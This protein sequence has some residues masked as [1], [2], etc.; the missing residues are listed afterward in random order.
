MYSILYRNR[1]TRLV[2]KL[3][4]PIFV[5][6]MT[7][8]HNVSTLAKGRAMNADSWTTVSPIV[9]RPVQHI[10]LREARVRIIVVEHTRVQRTVT[11]IEMAMVACAKKD[12]MASCARSSVMM[13]V[14]MGRHVVMAMDNAI[15]QRGSLSILLAT[16]KKI[17]KGTYVSAMSTLH[18]AATGHAL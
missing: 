9:Q 12:G 1:S 5:E 4:K 10:I 8:R 2:R 18:A 15:H 13:T 14:Q 16:V 3:A 7:N 6:G 17:G 11:V